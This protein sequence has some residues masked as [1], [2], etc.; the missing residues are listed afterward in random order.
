VFTIIAF[1][2]TAYCITIPVLVLLAWLPNSGRKKISI[3]LITVTNLLL[4]AHSVFLVKQLAGAYQLAKTYSIDYKQFLGGTNLAIRIGLIIFLPVFSLAPVF[5]RNQ[6]FSILLVGLLY[7]VYPFSSWNNYDLVFKIAGYLCL[8]CSGY[9]LLWLLN[10][11][12]YQ[13]RVV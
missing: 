5:R 9:A 8:L 13:S 1:I 7:S 3:N 2:K 4:I 6:L 10:K 12:P 11:L